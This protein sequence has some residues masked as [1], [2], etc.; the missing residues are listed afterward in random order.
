LKRAVVAE[1]YGSVLKKIY[2]D[3]AS[4]VWMA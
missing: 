3:A 2:G 1:K 4:A